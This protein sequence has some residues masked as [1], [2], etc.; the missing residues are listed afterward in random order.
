MARCAT[1]QKVPRNSLSVSEKPNNH[2]SPKN[3]TPT[4]PPSGIIVGTDTGTGR[5]P[6]IASSGKVTFNKYVTVPEVAPAVGG[7]SHMTWA[8]QYPGRHFTA[9]IVPVFSTIIAVAIPIA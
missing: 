7:F 1:F 2:R 6:N 5:N 8:G 3:S 4:K 9:D